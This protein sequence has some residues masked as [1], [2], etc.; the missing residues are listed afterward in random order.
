[1]VEE[2]K[3][4]LYLVRLITWCS[5]KV[6]GLMEKGLRGRGRCRSEMARTTRIVVYY[7][8]VSVI[9]GHLGNWYRVVMILWWVLF[10]VLGKRVGIVAIGG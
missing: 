8:R 7:S 6:R 3:G 9:Q 5:A 4:K 10:I 2:L 1:M